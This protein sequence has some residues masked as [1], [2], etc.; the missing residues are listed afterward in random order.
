MLTIDLFRI[1]SPLHS[2]YPS[3]A[4]PATSVGESGEIWTSGYCLSPGYWQND[5][6]TKKTQFTSNG[7]RWIRTGDIGI[8]DEGGYISIVGRAKEQIAR[9]GEKLSPFQI[10]NR[11]LQMEGILDASVI[12]VPDAFMGEVVGMYV[13]RALNEQ[14]NKLT[15]K[16][17]Y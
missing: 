11:A 5:E 3:P 6:E 10:E 1:V 2:L 4:T 9:G 12:G 13:K 7:E 14:G 17:S 15:R 8:M 16:V